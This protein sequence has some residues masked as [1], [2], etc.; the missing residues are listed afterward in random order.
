MYFKEIMSTINDPVVSIYKNPFS[1][2]LMNEKEIN[3]PF[4]FP[5]IIFTNNKSYGFMK[6]KQKGR[7]KRK[8]AR[9][10][11]LINKVLD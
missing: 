10:L 4:S 5:L 2:Q 11:T 6:E 7:L 8:I 3:N 1:N 9:R